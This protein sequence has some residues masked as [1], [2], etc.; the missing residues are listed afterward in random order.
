MS[1]RFGVFLPQGWRQD[2]DEIGDP[3]QQY[4]AMTHVARVAEDE[5]YDSLWVFDHFHAVPEPAQKTTFEAWTVT[6]TLARDTRR[7]HIGQLVTCA[8][9]RN[10]A[11]LAKMASTLNVASHGRLYVGLGAGWYVQEWRAYGNDFPDL[12]ERMDRF[13]EAVEIIHRMWTEDIP[14]FRGQYHHIERAINQPK[15]A[16]G[17]H[18]P[19]WLGGGGE[20][21]TLRLV[22]EQG[23][24]CNI[25][26]DAPTLRR[27]L[28]VL[29]QHCDMIGRECAEIIKSTAVAVQL[30]DDNRRPA[31]EHLSTVR[32]ES[33][34]IGTPVEVIERLCELAD[35]GIDYVILTFS[36][37]GLQLRTIAA[38]RSPG[39]AG[40]LESWSRCLKLSS[41]ARWTPTW[42]V[43]TSSVVELRP[44]AVHGK[45]KCGGG[46]TVTKE[47]RA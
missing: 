18:P 47:I 43:Y 2:L 15:G 40:V 13:R 46:R 9:Y 20:R 28:E 14:T 4:E 25:N 24:A 32:A 36:A 31:L 37:G 17:R 6:A 45:V 29:R 3:V 12:R 38:I 27:R 26:G 42:I 41:S 1:M 23:D 33:S 16:R 10:T 30:L 11:L 21:V 35:I 7:A 5:G 44:P 39:D 22:A 8:G 19:L 34:I